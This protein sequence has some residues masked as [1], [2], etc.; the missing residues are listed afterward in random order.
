MAVKRWQAWRLTQLYR[1]LYVDL[2]QLLIKAYFFDL[3]EKHKLHLDTTIIASLPSEND[4]IGWMDASL[5]TDYVKVM[6]KNN[7]PFQTENSNVT[8]NKEV[9]W[10]GNSV[11][12]SGFLLKLWIY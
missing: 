10:N 11:W 3:C 2:K 7:D 4:W 8:R 5:I 1:S 9:R 12:L 6:A